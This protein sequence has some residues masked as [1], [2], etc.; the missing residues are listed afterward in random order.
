MCRSSTATIFGAKLHFLWCNLDN[1]HCRYQ[2]A[3]NLMGTIN[4]G[5]SNRVGLI[6]QKIIGHQLFNSRLRETLKLSG[7]FEF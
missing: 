1:Y 2:S 4:G 6:K 5:T 3:N 7:C